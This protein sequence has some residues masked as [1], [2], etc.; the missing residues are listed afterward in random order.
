VLPGAHSEQLALGVEAPH[1]QLAASS[2]PK[3]INLNQPQSGALKCKFPA[4]LKQEAAE[5]SRQ[6]GNSAA[7]D[8]VEQRTGIRPARSTVS[9]WANGEQPNQGHFN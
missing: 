3:N 2:A 8:L 9:D 7:M 4:G 1:L 6:Q 5:V